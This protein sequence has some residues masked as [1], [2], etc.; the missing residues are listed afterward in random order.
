[1][2]NNRQ[3]NRPTHRISFA[4]IIGQDEKGNDQLGSAREVAS[5]WPRKAGGGIIRFDH[6]P[7]ELT[8]HEGVLF[9]TEVEAQDASERG[10]A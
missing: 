6:I 7:V 9:I 3:T 1:M 10:F 2:K 8:R 5:V 4:R